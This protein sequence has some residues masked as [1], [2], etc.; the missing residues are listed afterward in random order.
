M[1]TQKIDVVSKWEDSSMEGAR[2][3]NPFF[4]EN[5]REIYDEIKVLKRDIDIHE[6]RKKALEMQV[7]RLR[8]SFMEYVKSIETLEKSKAYQRISPSSKLTHSRILKYC[9]VFMP[10]EI[11][12]CSLID[13]TLVSTIKKACAEYKQARIRSELLFVLKKER[14]DPEECS[15]LERKFEMYEKNVNY[16]QTK[17]NFSLFINKLSLQLMKSIIGEVE[18]MQKISTEHAKLCLAM[19][20]IKEY[21]YASSDNALGH[22][23]SSELS[24][25]SKLSPEEIERQKRRIANDYRPSN[26]DQLHSSTPQKILR[27]ITSD[28]TSFIMKSIHEPLIYSFFAQFTVGE[29]SFRGTFFL[30]KN[31]LVIT[32]MIF[33]WKY[34]LQKHE[35]I[36]FLK[37]KSTVE[38]DT[39][40]YQITAICS[41]K[42]LTALCNWKHELSPFLNNEILLGTTTERYSILFEHMFELPVDHQDNILKYS[43]YTLLNSTILDNR[44]RKRSFK[45]KIHIFRIPFT[46]T[47]NETYLIEHE[48]KNS[49]IILIY[50]EISLSKYIPDIMGISKIKIEEIEGNTSIYYSF[51]QLLSSILLKPIFIPIIQN[52]V[53]SIHLSNAVTLPGKLYYQP[54]N[55][56]IFIGVGSLVG[57]LSVILST[58]YMLKILLLL[59]KE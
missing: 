13:T 26:E 55:L 19:E 3:E 46:L 50:S 33:G 7:D 24:T 59:Y 49:A 48:S 35:I 40:E 52:T 58:R 41:N 9:H 28:R 30:F 27:K 34:Y 23:V 57:I 17:I 18:N 29:D 38:I 51:E 31:C 10:P 2:E 36:L 54:Y 22:S 25:L 32:E 14:P 4:L 47:Y 16:T 8:A 21:Q 15:E 11:P 5:A 1:K 37:N 42:D 39:T 45:K 20:C 12:F 43:G 56:T 44:I 6:K 53:C